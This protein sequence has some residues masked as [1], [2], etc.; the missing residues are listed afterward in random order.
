MTKRVFLLFFAAALLFLCA[1]RAPG[2][3][4]AA[5]HTSSSEESSSNSA[6]FES[7]DTKDF[8][9][10]LKS[11]SMNGKVYKFPFP[12]S[13]LLDDGFAFEKGID[14][15]QLSYNYYTC[16]KLTEK[17]GKSL[18]VYLYN[19]GFESEKLPSLS[20]YG[21]SVNAKEKACGCVFGKNA[22]L[23][24]DIK[25]IA[26]ELGKPTQVSTSEKAVTTLTYKPEKNASK[27]QIKFEFKSGKCSDISLTAPFV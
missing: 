8:T 13:N 2:K 1:C 4:S 22:K 10:A 16:V 11:F 5:S 19:G 24:D 17:S 9:Y 26:K 6:Y 15:T 18:E 7:L 21:V 12:V 23:G 3:A 27:N 25:D 20:V 14:E